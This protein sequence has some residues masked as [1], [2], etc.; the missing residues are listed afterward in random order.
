MFKRLAIIIAITSGVLYFFLS[1]NPSKA[2]WLDF[3]YTKRD[4]L[5]IKGNLVYLNGNSVI[6]LHGVAMGNPYL[7]QAKSYRD[8]SDYE[9]VKSWHANIVRLSVHPGVYKKDEREIK[10]ALKTE[11]EAARNQGLFVI[12]D[13]HV[14]GYPNGNYMGWADGP[15]KGVYYDSKMQ[16][17][18]D[19]WKY[20]ATEFRD[21]RGVVFE[22]WNE[23]SD[24][25][26]PE[27]NWNEINPYIQRLHDVVRSR[28]ANNI[29]LAPGTFWSYDLRGVKGNPLKGNNIGYAW[30]MYPTKDNYISWDR[31]MDGLYRYYPVFVTEWGYSTE[32]MGT[33]FSLSKA[34]SY[35]PEKLKNYM[36]DNNLHSTAWIWHSDWQP[37]M[38][39]DDW[40]TPTPFGRFVKAFLNDMSLGKL[41][42]KQKKT[43]VRAAPPVTAVDLSG[44]YQ[45][46]VNAFNKK[47]TSDAELKDL[48]RIANGQEPLKRSLASEARA[49]TV[50]KK[51]YGR[52]PR[53]DNANDRSAVMAIT[54]GVRQKKAG[55][56]QAK[57]KTATSTF[58]EI[59][60][61]APSLIWEKGAVQA[62]A[63]S[64]VKK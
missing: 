50:F 8:E 1:A 29:V 7:R 59:F 16:L 4:F 43:I 18:E 17:A 26:R 14:I 40:Q 45:A 63:Y 64:G 23:P 57:E 22:L 25:K 31:A 32:Q 9:I 37:R 5:N 30:H 55:A 6:K 47:P 21:D 35:F 28:G 52:S 54:Y 19:F 44:P 2:G 20:A 15:Y 51:I 3:L 24:D 49:K 33:H 61:H 41:K 53:M 42:P 12:I 56:S 46:Y 11:V 48:S 60:G 62:L 34:K 36:V 39:D 38:L 13:W 58:M 27:F 10:K